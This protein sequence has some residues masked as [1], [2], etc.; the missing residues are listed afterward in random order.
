MWQRLAKLYVG[1]IYAWTS[2]GFASGVYN[3]HQGAG[4]ENDLLESTLIGMCFG[5]AQP[6][7]IPLTPAFA[8]G[9]LLSE[10]K[11]TK[12]EIEEE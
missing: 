7:W 8:V 10:N 4:N 6:L 1:S 3:M 5:M 12:I 2:L 9:Y 11:I